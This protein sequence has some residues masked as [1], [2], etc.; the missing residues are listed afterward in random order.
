LRTDGI[1]R[2]IGLGIVRAI[3]END[4]LGLFRR[5]ESCE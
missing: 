2:S 1:A 4:R 5:S 3:A